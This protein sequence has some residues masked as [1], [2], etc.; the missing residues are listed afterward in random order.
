M[1]GTLLYNG[2]AISSP[3][4]AYQPGEEVKALTE[5]VKCAVTDGEAI[6]NNPYDEY[7]GRS[8]VQQANEAQRTWLSHPDAPYVGEDE[9]RWNGVRPL[10]RNRVIYTTARLTSQLL[11]PKSFAQNDAQEEDREAAYAM[12]SLVEFNIRNSNYET[13]FLFGVISALVNPLNYFSVDYCESWQ[14]A[15]QGGEY[16]RVIDDI[17]SGFQN[18]LIPIDE[19]LFSN[20]YVYEW[21]Q[22]DWIIRTRRVSYEEMEGK[23]GAHDNW[24]HVKMGQVSMKHEDGFFYDVED[25]TDGM[26]GH[27]NYKHRR[28]DCELDFVN[29]IYLSNP[30][31]EWNPFYH[32]RIKTVKGEA[33]EVPLYNTVKYGYE[34]IDAMRFV[35]YKALVDKM[36]G[37]QDGADREWQDF[38]DASRLATFQPIVLMGAGKFDHSV[39]APSAVTEIGK[40]AKVQPIQVTNP[41]PALNALREAERSG[42]ESSVDPSAGGIQSGPQKTK[43]EAALLEDNTDTNLSLTAKLIARMVKEIGG[44]LIDDIVRYQTIGE[45]GEILGETL[46]KTFMIDGRIREGTQKTTY[47]KFTDRFAGRSMSDEEKATEGYQLMEEAGNDRELIEVNPGV[48]ARMNWLVSADAEQLTRRNTAFER[49]FKLAAYEKAI[50]NPLVMADPEAQLKITRDFLFEPIM[51]GDASKYLPRIQKVANTIVPGATPPVSE[52][53]PQP[54]TVVPTAGGGMVQ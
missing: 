42:N 47:I 50:A 38:F 49:T 45:A 16:K 4:S 32:R 41:L 2:E 22:Q 34:P 25:I 3:K 9:W 8:F 33:V 18:S 31:T 20:P 53:S 5:T 43:Y 23:F 21:Q 12:D 35:G 19:I 39:V 51:K 13:A 1:K 52:G 24:Q 14:E 11:Y 30:N 28:S 26:V 17:F 10:T 29:G 54:K 37:D 6:L 15:W 48:F 46:Y 36:S 27:V 7:N 40:D 44:L